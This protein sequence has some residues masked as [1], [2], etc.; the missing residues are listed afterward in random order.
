MNNNN[1][2]CCPKFNPEKWDKKIFKWNNKHFIKET[3]PTFFHI[4]FPPMIGKSITK[5]M[6]LA[7]DS[8]KIDSKKD[9]ILILFQDP[10]AFKSNIYLSVTGNVPGAN[11]I[12]VSGTFVA[13]VYD[14][15]Y[16][17][18]PKFIQ[19]MNKY[20]EKEGKKIA[21]DSEYYVHYSYCPQCEK[22]YGHNYM[23]LFARV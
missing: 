1:N 20:L 14:G 4:P 18:I 11:N 10:S 2:D 8:N 17:A 19:D 13:R 6:S 9:E 23:I 3:I 5:M 12:N 7:T 15:P 21:K 16:N 22:K